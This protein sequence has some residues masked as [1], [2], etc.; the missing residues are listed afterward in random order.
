[1]FG[2]SVCS[3]ASPLPPLVPLMS[4]VNRGSDGSFHSADVVRA[5][6]P[7]GG[8]VFAMGTMELAW[9]LD[10]LDGRSPNRQV[11]AFVAAALRD[12]TRPARRPAH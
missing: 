9:T 5:T 6:A 3:R 2:P 4:A 12:L 1:M 8:R 7:S 11:V 10:D